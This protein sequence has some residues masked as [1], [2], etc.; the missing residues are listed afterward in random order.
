MIDI[1]T[2]AKKATTEHEMAYIA[3]RIMTVFPETAPDMSGR[4]LT[5]KENA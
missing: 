1:I 5:P 2:K 4:I 3:D